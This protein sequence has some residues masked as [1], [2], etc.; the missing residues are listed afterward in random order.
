[1]GW[2]E[3]GVESFV[4]VRSAAQYSSG[5]DVRESTHISVRTYLQST[6]IC[7]MPLLPSEA[8]VAM[9]TLVVCKALT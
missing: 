7:T 9:T 1:M 2:N 3:C 6:F 4:P 8:R 5:R